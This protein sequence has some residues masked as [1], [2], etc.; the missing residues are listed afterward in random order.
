MIELT[1]TQPHESELAWLEAYRW[2]RKMAHAE[3]CRAVER[4]M[5]APD[6]REA[7]RGFDDI[8]ALQGPI[9]TIATMH[10]MAVKVMSRMIPEVTID[11]VEGIKVKSP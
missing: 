1:C 11:P 4:I 7:R 2:D 10:Q 8:Q 6:W 3:L 5:T 9:M